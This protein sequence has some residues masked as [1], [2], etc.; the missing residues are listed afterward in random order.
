MIGVSDQDTPRTIKIS[1]VIAF[2]V[3]YVCSIV[4][5]LCLE[6]IDITV[7]VDWPCKRDLESGSDI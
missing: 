2:Q 3:W 5:W 4:D 7:N 1:L 6:P